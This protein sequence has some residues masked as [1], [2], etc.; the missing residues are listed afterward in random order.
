MYRM[1]RVF[2]A[3]SWE[4]EG[5]RRAFYDLIGEFNHNQAMA[6]GILYVPVS[7]TNVRDK[8]PYQFV[9]EE[10]IRDCRHYIAALKD[11]WGPP[12]RNFRDDFRL[13]TACREDAGLPLTGVSLLLRTTPDGPP[14][15]VA[16]LEKAGISPVLFSG[17][18]E[19]RERVLA[20]LSAWMELDAP[21]ADATGA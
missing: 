3:T 7:L 19:F 11:D 15:F 21:A 4:L 1:H 17:V 6:R 9:V 10:N 16:D 2:C 13:A 8:R 5:E 20:L 18:P 12:E 14:P